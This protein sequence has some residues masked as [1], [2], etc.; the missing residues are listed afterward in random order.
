M[1]YGLWFL[2]PKEN[3]RIL[4]TCELVNFWNYSQFLVSLPGVALAKTGGLWF[5]RPTQR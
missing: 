3:Y 4:K 2:Q 1:V 5:P